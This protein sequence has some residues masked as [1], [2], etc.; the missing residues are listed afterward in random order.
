MVIAVSHASGSLYV[1]RFGLVETSDPL[2]TSACTRLTVPGFQVPFRVDVLE[3]TLLATGSLSLGKCSLNITA[4][5]VQSH[6][7][8]VGLK[9]LVDNELPSSSTDS[10]CTSYLLSEFRLATCELDGTVAIWELRPPRLVRS[11]RLVGF[12]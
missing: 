12:S 3:Q 7:G 2:S 6:S 4:K 5:H 8:S 9:L 10:M 11:F 1:V